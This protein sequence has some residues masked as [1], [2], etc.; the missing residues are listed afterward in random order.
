METVTLSVPTVHCHAC[1][2]NIEEALDELAG[3]DTCRVDLATKIG[4]AHLRPRRRRAPGDHRGARG[5][6][7]PGRLISSAGR[8][9]RRP[10]A[11]SA[12]P[13]APSWPLNS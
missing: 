9:R 8:G 10:C 4:D 1:K 5:R 11:R 7:L 13:P 12:P 6:R 3:V 2:M